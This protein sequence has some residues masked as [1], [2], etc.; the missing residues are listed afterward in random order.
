VDW[1]NW[2]VVGTSVMMRRENKMGEYINGKWVGNKKGSTTGEPDL[3]LLSSK[4][5]IGDQKTTGLKKEE[6]WPSKPSQNKKP[7]KGPPTSGAYKGKRGEQAPQRTPQHHRTW[8]G[9]LFKLI[10]KKGF[11]SPGFKDDG[12][13]GEK[14]REKRRL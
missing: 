11:F 6:V 10:Y 5:W 4:G 7:S 9:K 1:G 2:N 3:P 8:E 13:G 12:R 14:K